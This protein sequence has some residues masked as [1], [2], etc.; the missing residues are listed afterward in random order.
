[1]QQEI[2]NALEV[3]KKGGLILYPTDTVWGIGCDASNEEAVKKI[4]ALK[5]RLE[6]SSLIILVDKEAKLNNYLSDV[7]ALAY[8][9]MDYAEKPLSII[10]SHAK[11]LAKNVI[12][13]DG[14]V[15]IRI[16]KDEF[17]KKLIEK[18]GKPIVSTSANS[19]GEATPANFSEI[20]K[21]VI[22]GVD[23]VVNHRQDEK[24][25]QAPSSIIKLEL[26]GEIKIIRK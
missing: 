22:D 1:M 5:G 11:N 7:P 8:D 24:I 12:N 15:G 23:Y 25:K 16:V 21:T 26:N 17:C 4:Y 20:K 6:S 14:S 10:Y 9:L 2:N 18:F 13:Q 3:L 19:S